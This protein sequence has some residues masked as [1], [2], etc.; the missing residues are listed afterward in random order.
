M[1]LVDLTSSDAL[2]RTMAKSKA[3]AEE[4]DLQKAIEES[5][6][7]NGRQQSDNLMSAAIA[8]SLLSFTNNPA[9]DPA[10]RR[11]QNEA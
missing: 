10:S 9:T 1:D 8:Q 11:R 7:G 6:K 3:E 4:S 2:Q 5:V